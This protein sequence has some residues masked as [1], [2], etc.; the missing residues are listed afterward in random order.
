MTKI[1][2]FQK[3][4]QQATKQEPLSDAVKNLSMKYIS[5]LNKIICL[6]LLAGMGLFLNGCLAGY[7]TTEPVYV[8][9]SRPQRPSE[10]HIWIDGDWSYNSQ[11]HGYV[12]NTGYWEKPRQGQTF[13][14]GHWQSTPKGKSWSKGHWQKQGR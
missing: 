4:I 6:T 5:R 3:D 10:M 1:E 7:V 11:S 14:S 12:Q 8:E 2:I 9:H 13:V